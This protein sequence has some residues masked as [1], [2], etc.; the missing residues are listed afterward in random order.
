MRRLLAPCCSPRARPWP[1]GRLPGEIVT[2]IGQVAALPADA[3]KVPGHA[4]AWRRAEAQQRVID[5]IEALEARGDKPCRA[6]RWRYRAG[7]PDLIETRPQRVHHA[8]ER[9]TVQ[10]CGAT[11]VYDV[12]YRF[13]RGASRLVVA[14]SD[15]TEFQAVLDPPYR[16]LR[17][18]AAARQAEEA[19]GGVRWL[20]LPL[21]GDSVPVAN[22]SGKGGW[23]ADFVPLG[24]DPREWTQLIGVQGLPRSKQPG[25]ALRLLEYAGRPRPPLR[26]A[27][28]PRRNPAARGQRQRRGPDLPRLPPGAGHQ[29]RRAGRGEGHRGP[30]QLYVVQRAWRLP[31]GKADALVADSRGPGQRRRPFWPRC[32]CATRQTAAPARRRIRAER[33]RLAGWRPTRP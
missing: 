6:V 26:R 5:R 8:L 22:H 11:R 4:G 16:R 27:R 19:G 14:D 1:T 7:R 32:A 18:L 29:L 3:R 9:W 33:R 25:Q 10:A 20:N 12:W 30:D 23:S 15:A 21:P 17:E 13:E 28:R 2:R 31:A 24:D